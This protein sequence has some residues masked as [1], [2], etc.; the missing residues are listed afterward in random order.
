MSIFYW[1]ICKEKMLGLIIFWMGNNLGL[2]NLYIF[3]RIKC[4]RTNSVT[5]KKILNKISPDSE[6]YQ[7]L[8][9]NMGIL[10]CKCFRSTPW[11]LYHEI[12]P[13]LALNSGWSKLS[14][15]SVKMEFKNYENQLKTIYFTTN[16]VSSTRLFSDI[17]VN[18]KLTKSKPKFSFWCTSYFLGG[19]PRGE[20]FGPIFS[21]VLPCQQFF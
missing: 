21:S 15:A 17:C 10:I 20:W 5:R 19:L 2:T 18:V 9:S 4:W 16:L 11:N 7:I 1:L 8:F 6:A 3:V 14:Q 12:I 13:H